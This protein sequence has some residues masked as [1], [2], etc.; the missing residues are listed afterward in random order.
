M[1]R[2]RGE[3]RLLPALAQSP[4]EIAALP[5]V[6]WAR[7]YL[8]LEPY[9]AQRKADGAELMGFYHRQVAE[10]AQ[11]DYRDT[12]RHAGLAAYFTPQPLYLDP[13]E[14]APNL[15]KLSEMVYQQ[16]WAGLAAQVERALLD[17]PYLQ[18]KLAGQGVQELIEDYAWVS[19][20]RRGSKKE[21][22]LSLAARRA[23]PVGTPCWTATPCSSRAN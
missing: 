19:K 9:L 13:D 10:A 1:A 12:E 23:A 18:A 15:R 5:V 16:A 2:W 17:Y 20:A 11:A 21:K 4:Q 6:I 3:G 8:D 7:L 22:S 14:Q